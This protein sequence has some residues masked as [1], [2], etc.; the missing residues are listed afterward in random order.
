MDSHDWQTVF[1]Y[2]AVGSLLFGFIGAFFI[3]TFAVLIARDTRL[4]EAK[5]NQ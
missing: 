4:F 3:F 2:C 5:E 1:A